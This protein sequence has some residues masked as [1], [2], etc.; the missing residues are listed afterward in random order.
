MTIKLN[1]HQQIL[2]DALKA[3]GDW[4]SRDE[5][6]QA[7]GKV[8]LTPEDVMALDQLES[9]GMLV[10]EISDNLSPDGQDVRYRYAVPKVE[11]GTTAV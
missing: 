8:H 5:L 11:P 7:T 1:Q 9:S 6:A 3:R 10:K 4:T 2:I